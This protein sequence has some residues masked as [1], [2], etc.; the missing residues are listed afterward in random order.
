MT[1]VVRW[2]TIKVPVQ[3]YD[4][5]LPYLY[6]SLPETPMD[7]TIHLAEQHILRFESHLKHIDEM[8]LKA[9][10]ARAAG[11][12]DEKTEL[13]R[14]RQ[15]RDKLAQALGSYRGSVASSAPKAVDEAEEL[16]GVFQ[17][18]G[19][20]LEKIIATVVDPQHKQH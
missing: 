11:T 17:S 13:D 15:D 19:L 16:K 18:V 4:G 5:A 12:P 6:A 3:L 1:S 20:Q 7:E 9:Q 14:I 2:R 10:Q 8:M